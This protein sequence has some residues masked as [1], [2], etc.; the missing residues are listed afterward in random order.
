MKIHDRQHGS[1]YQTTT[2][3]TCV[4]IVAAIVFGVGS[5]MAKPR[6]PGPPWPEAG[7]I[8]SESFDQPYGMPTNQV[9]DTT[10]WADSWSGY[11]LDRSSSPVAAW[12]IPM[13]VTNRPLVDPTSGAIRFWYRPGHDSG[14]G[15]GNI[16]RLLTLASGSG[17]TSAIWWSLAVSQDE[18][19]RA[20]I[21]RFG[22]KAIQNIDNVVEVSPKV[23]HDLNVLYSSIRED[24]TGSGTQTVRQWLNNQSFARQA[25]FRR[26]AVQNVLGGVWP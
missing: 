14:S 22:A 11:C 9:I 4:L 3:L 17:S 5:L 23:N 26:Q 8:Y 19:R 13:V 1:P 21:E 18:Q 2:A 12:V 6:P 24:I 25:V 10:V 16:A 15:P 20:N 7:L